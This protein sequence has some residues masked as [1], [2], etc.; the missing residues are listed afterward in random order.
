MGY[1]KFKGGTKNQKGFV[2][3]MTI[4]QEK[5]S[6]F[7]KWVSMDYVFSA[8][9]D[10]SHGHNSY[11]NRFYNFKIYAHELILNSSTSFTTDL[12]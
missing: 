10:P 4:F 7:E 2:P 12:F 6:Y 11:K 3:N 1:G 5:N 8:K 9:F